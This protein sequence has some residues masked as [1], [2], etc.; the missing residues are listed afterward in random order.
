MSPLNVF[1]LYF[2][3]A[4]MFCFNQQK[5]HPI[6]F[7]EKKEATHVARS[8]FKSLYFIFVNY[9]I[10]KPIIQVPTENCEQKKLQ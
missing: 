2:N 3:C 9:K 5:V 7:I 10:Y 8:T 6:F 4:L 1:L